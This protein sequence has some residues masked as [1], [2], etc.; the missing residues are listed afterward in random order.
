MVNFFE[1]LEITSSGQV[2][3]WLNSRKELFTKRK[4][5]TL[6][7]N[8]WYQT[9]RISDD[10]R[11]SCYVINLWRYVYVWKSFVWGQKGQDSIFSC[12]EK[13]NV[14]V[15]DVIRRKAASCGLRMS[16]GGG[17]RN[18]WQVFGE[19]FWKI[20]LKNGQER[21]SLVAPCIRYW[22]QSPAT[23]RKVIYSVFWSGSVWFSVLMC[24][25]R[26]FLWSPM[27][28]VLAGAA[29]GREWAGD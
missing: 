10:I 16:W 11:T 29:D 21:T 22:Q 14:S 9:F 15:R 26:L 6:Q 20:I 4:T 19:N 24:F 28:T 27:Q 3:M 17:G 18:H 5:L 25:F 23:D 12:S 2:L 8:L 13:S 1:R 7:S